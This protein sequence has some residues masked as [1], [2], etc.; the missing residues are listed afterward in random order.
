MVLM[1]QCATPRDFGH[2]PCV[3]RSGAGLTE[4]YRILG[5]YVLGHRD[6]VTK[7][8]SLTKS[9]AAYRLRADSPVAQLHSVP[10][11]APH[12]RLVS[13]PHGSKIS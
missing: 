9:E 4:A 8:S 1:G 10:D 7:T 2:G 11:Y 3:A 5:G 13:L 12:I 6:M